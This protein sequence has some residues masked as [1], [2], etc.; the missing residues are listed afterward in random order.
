MYNFCWTNVAGHSCPTGFC[1]HFLSLYFWATIFC[2]WSM[3]RY[4]RYPVKRLYFVWTEVVNSTAFSKSMFWAIE[5]AIWSLQKSN[6]GRFVISDQLVNRWRFWNTFLEQDLE[7]FTNLSFP[8]LL[9]NFLNLYPWRF[10]ISVSFTVW[11]F[12]NSFLQLICSHTYFYYL[13]Q[14]LKMHEEQKVVVLFKANGQAL[15]RAVQCLP[16]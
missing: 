10:A 15:V 3:F 11:L 12:N 8:Q 16:N 1:S 9:L 6:K 13:P 4:R 7:V 14:L 5:K 2:K